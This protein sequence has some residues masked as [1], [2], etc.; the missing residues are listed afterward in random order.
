M[1]KE[2]TL[3]DNLFYLGSIFL[4]MSLVAGALFYYVLL[5][6]LSLPPCVLYAYFGLYCP[7][8]GGTRAFISLLHG[9]F[10]LSLWYHPLVLYSALLFGAFMI[11]QALAR[12][13]RFRYFRGLS[14]HNWYLYVAI[15]IVGFNWVIK[16]IL[17]LVWGIRL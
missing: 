11:T 12:L 1:K 10:L 14:F 7:G 4:G 2:R 13:T 9:H 3:E 8:C 5:P 15:G 17:L 16:N 6:H